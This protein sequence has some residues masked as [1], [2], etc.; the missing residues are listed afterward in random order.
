MPFNPLKPNRRRDS[1]TETTSIKCLQVNVVLKV[2][3]IFQLLRMILTNKKKIVIE[4]IV[5][6][7]INLKTYVC[8]RLKL[9][10]IFCSQVIFLALIFY[11]AKY[12]LLILQLSGKLEIYF[13]P[14]IRISP[15]SGMQIIRKIDL[16]KV[17]ISQYSLTNTAAGT[18]LVSF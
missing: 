2:L 17:L 6:T 4:K 15:S 18:I 1:S 10:H 8:Q 16:L 9:Y 14:F 5:N 7:I 12:L 13:Y 11:A 3:C